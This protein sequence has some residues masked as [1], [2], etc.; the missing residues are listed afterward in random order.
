M[1]DIAENFSEND[2]V[3]LY[4]NTMGPGSKNTIILFLSGLIQSN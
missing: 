3:Y 2:E 4:K 1:Q